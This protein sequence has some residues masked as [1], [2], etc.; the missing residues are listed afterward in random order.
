MAPLGSMW[1]QFSSSVVAEQFFM[2][3]NHD[4]FLTDKKKS[5]PSKFVILKYLAIENGFCILPLKCI[6]EACF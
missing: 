3:L 2:A 6:Y 4:L 1:D 5:T